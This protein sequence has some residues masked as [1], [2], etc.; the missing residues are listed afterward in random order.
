MLFK[1]GQNISLYHI[2]VLPVLSSTVIR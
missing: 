1:R 2:S